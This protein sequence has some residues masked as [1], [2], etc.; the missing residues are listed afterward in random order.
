METISVIV[1]VYNCAAQVGRCL[2]SLLGQ[3]KAVEIVAVDDGSSDGSRPVL[4]EYEKAYPGRIRVIRQE[5]AGV[6]AARLAGV[7]AASGNWIGFVDGDD[8]VEPGMYQHLLKLALSADAEIAHCGHQVHYPDG[9]V[10]YVFNS[11]TRWVRDQA[12]GLRDLLDGGQ[13]NSSLCTKLF[14][15][16]LFAG[17]DTWM[18]AALK[19]GEDLLMNYYLFSRA[20]KSV[21]EDVCLYH[22][23]LRE[24]SASHHQFNEH[25]LFD[26]VK[27]RKRILERCG[28]D[29]KPDAQRALLRN[30]LF[31]Y[32]QASLQPMEK[33]R[34]YRNRAR[35]MLQER[36]DQFFLLS[37]R[38]RVLAEMICAAPWSFDLSY[39]AYTRVFRR[40]EEH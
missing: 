28:A 19:N 3:T 32:A 38:N 10:D 13:I 12:G 21:Y 36:K 2:D 37:W 22:Y 15:R 6:T 17:I 39:G 8:A 34:A 27:A 18:D 4:E 25:V 16:E 1:P 5:N 14:R 23:W 9:R 7:R 20:E 40:K 29:L 26:P 31:A 11:G 24:G 30:L 35:A 33:S